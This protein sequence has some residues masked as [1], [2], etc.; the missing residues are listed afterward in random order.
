[1]S[2]AGRDTVA[3]L[4]PWV[5]VALRARYAVL[6][7][8]GVLPALWHLHTNGGVGDWG[9]FR[10]A[11][12]VLSGRSSTAPLDLYLASPQTQIGPPAL[13]LALPVA[14]LPLPLGWWVLVLL[15]GCALPLCCRWLEDAARAGGTRD[16]RIE[17]V[18]VTGGLLAGTYWWRIAADYSHP[19]DVMAIATA[20]LVL[21]WSRLHPSSSWHPWLSAMLLGVAAAGKPWAVGFTVLAAAWSAPHALRA[22]RVLSAGIVAG[23]C[24]LPFVLAAP[25]SL[26]RLGAF[27]VE[28]WST[29]PLALLGY[30]GVVYPVWVRPA[31]FALAVG[32][33]G[34]AVLRRRAD[35]APFAAVAARIALDPQA[36]DYYF[37]TTAVAALAADVLRP[38]TRGPWVTLTTIALL[39]DARWLLDDSWSIA[40]IQSLPVLVAVVL[41][42]VGPVGARPRPAAGGHRPGSSTL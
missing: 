40:A 31:Q 21:K 14:L 13:L 16:P 17:L 29:S 11:A 26:T 4:P 18:V 32:L 2:S 1:M 5:P 10:S 30:G 23:A 28:V 38:G 37:A 19:E 8:V 9:V 15:T 27:R 24:W 7:L 20:C 42:L 22:A 6:L 33:A 34:V 39:Y 36:W 12:E 35:L 41:L 25:E 3:L